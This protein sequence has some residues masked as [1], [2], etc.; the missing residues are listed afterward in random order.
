MTAGATAY[1]G[2]TTGGTDN[3]SSALTYIPG[4]RLE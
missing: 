1:W 3:I 4:N 2:A